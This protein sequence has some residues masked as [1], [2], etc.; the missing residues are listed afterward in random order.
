M[1]SNL[2]SVMKLLDDARIEMRCAAAL[3]L[4]AVGKGDG[5]V[6][7]ALTGKLGDDNPVVRRIALDSLADMGA[8][9]IA[10]AV[11]PL[12]RSEDEHVA[13]RAIQVLAG[14]GA[15]VEVVLRKELG[16]GSPSARR[17]VA[18]LLLK[19]GTVGSIDPLLEQLGDHDFGEHVLQ[20]LR[21]ELDVGG[22]KLAA[23]VDARAHEAIARI[24]KE[25]AAG[26]KERAAAARKEGKARKEGAA[27]AAAP[28][29]PGKGG[30]ARAEAAAAP[31]GKANGHGATPADP[32][33]GPQLEHA[34]RELANLL[35]LIGYVADPAS[36]KQLVR[37]S[38][39][40]QPLAVRLAAIAAMR[41]I[42]AASDARGTEAAIAALIEYANDGEHAISQAAIDTLRGA[43]I[44]DKLQKAFAALGRS[45]NPAAQRVALERMPVSGA[46]LKTLV[47]NLVSGEPDARDTAARALAHAPEA[48]TPLAKAL[49]AAEDEGVARRLAGALRGHRGHVPEATIELLVAAVTALLDGKRDGDFADAHQA[50]GVERTIAEAIAEL[51]PQA[52]VG[53]L[54]TRAQRLR[55]AGRYHDAFASLRPLLRSRA[56]LGTELDDEQRFFLAVLGLK[57]AGKDIVRAAHKGDPLLDQFSA[58]AR[59]GFPL[60][61][62]LTRQ[63]DLEDE[64][65][66]GLG[67]C[68]LESHDENDKELGAEILRGIIDERPRSKLAKACKNKLKL[69]NMD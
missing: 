32:A 27:K 21:A 56:D 67:F 52:H 26:L 23:T 35:R 30:K 11:A 14:Q 33:L 69:S 42:G 29:R 4:G 17:Q 24:G 51:A 41:R 6:V 43:R 18:M 63:K 57:I 50:R 46:T 10:A 37:Y 61:K 59:G 1:A 34:V 49:A 7:K 31:G 20:L 66:Y 8:T 54:F 45:K 58:L 44:P 22:D 48:V 15:G 5:T 25:V 53:L 13:A 19:R 9:G 40:E 3:V 2:S 36:L 60:V 39:A 55:R 12:V 38:D 16:V 68:L 64:D 28:G 65:I 62:E 47:D